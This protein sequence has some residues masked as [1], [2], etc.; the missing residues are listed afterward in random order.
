MGN[1][2][3]WLNATGA[4]VPLHYGALHTYEKWLVPI[5][6][7]GPFVVMF[8]VVYFVRKRDNDERHEA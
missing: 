3:D 1:W 8:V 6:G 7:I 5:V 4:L 2:L